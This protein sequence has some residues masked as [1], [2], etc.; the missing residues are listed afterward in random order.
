MAAALV[1]VVPVPM[2]RG[3]G[4]VYEGGKVAT[5]QEEREEEQEEQEIK[6]VVCSRGSS[7]NQQ[8]SVLPAIPNRR[9][10]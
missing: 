9:R 4:Q 1:V 3:R 7:R 8:P 2:V 10:R 6:Q 5:E